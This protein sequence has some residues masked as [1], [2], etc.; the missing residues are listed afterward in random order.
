MII[1]VQTYTIRK[2]FQTEEDIDFTLGKLYN[3]GVRNLEL[4]YYPFNVESIRLL[5][6]YLD[7]YSM[8]VTSC[9]IKYQVIVKKFDEIISILKMIGCKYLAISVI[10]FRR[11]LMGT[12]GL[13]R[14]AKE[15]NALGEKTRNNGIQLL[16]HHHNY[17]FIKFRNKLA[18]DI[19]MEKLDTDSV[20][21]LSDTYWIKKGGFSCL[22]FLEKHHG[23]I[24]ALHLRGYIHT[25]DSNLAENEIDFK[26]VIEYAIN[27]NFYYA[28][29]EQNTDRP[30]EELEKSINYVIDAGFGNYFNKKNENGGMING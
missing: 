13:H 11:L 30:L 3:F 19:L 8:T 7:K 18:F 29:I 28:V 20:Q 2:I 5:K 26:E 25:S 16:F 1:G 17:E 9:Q 15:L 4:A 6:K 21:I 23:A 10:P 22:E 14:L 27:N 24:K 12:K